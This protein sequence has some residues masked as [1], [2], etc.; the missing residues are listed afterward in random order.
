MG[1]H[2]KEVID[3]HIHK[4][5]KRAHMKSFSKI[6]RIPVLWIVLW[7]LGNGH[8]AAEEKGIHKRVDDLILAGKLREAEEIAEKAYRKNPDDVETICA[9]ACVYRNKAYKSGIR[10]DSSKLGL[11]ENESGSAEL[12]P[13]LIKEAFKEETFYDEEIFANAEPLYHRAIALDKN[14]LNAYFNLLNTYM[15]MGRFDKY[16]NVI[17]LFLKN[18]KENRNSPE[19][20][21]D[22]AAKLFRQKSYKQAERLYKIILQ[23]YPDD[24]HAKS[25]LGAAYLA[26]GKIEQAAEIF[27]E[28]FEKDPADAINANNL[29][30]AY[31]LQEKF[32]DALRVAESLLGH[33]DGDYFN[34]FYAGTLALLTGKKYDDYLNR[35]IQIRTGE[36]ENPQNDFYIQVSRKYLNFSKLEQKGKLTFLE[37]VLIQFYQ[38]DYNY[39][40]I[41][42]ANISLKL[43]TT[44]NPLI[45]M[46]A[47]FD[48]RLN[49]P[50]KAIEYLD[51]I[52]EYR[53]KDP[54]IMT[55]YHLNYN[56]GRNHYNLDRF[57]E[58]IK[59][60]TINFNEKKDDADLLYGLGMAYQK[61]GDT[62]NA[63]KYYNMGSRLTDKKNMYGINASIRAAV[64][65]DCHHKR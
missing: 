26:T 52:S 62:E 54:S 46:A 18:R 49:H 10:V 61:K 36:V 2:A 12:T 65:L 35:F 30:T 38:N 44:K 53:K 58:A 43:E 31:L 11:K 1:V 39:F 19:I 7:L 20:L 24:T 47:I 37:P 51:K 33:K 29:M 6:N 59:F 41:I 32:S 28:V 55:A 3:R 60:F 16:F 21:L 63:C 57:D 42:T 4:L 8:L 14:Y 13:D 56:Y 40:A 25:D 15:V 9:R 27:K 17:D 45:V 34:F 48:T 64:K 23:A 50:E 22:L 5:Q